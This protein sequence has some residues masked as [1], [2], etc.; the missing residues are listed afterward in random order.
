[1]DKSCHEVCAQCERQASTHCLLRG[2]PGRDQTTHFFGRATRHAGRASSIS[3]R[4]TSSPCRRAPTGDLGRSLV[5]RSASGTMFPTSLPSR[6][7]RGVDRM[8]SCGGRCKDFVR[9]ATRAV[10]HG[11]DIARP[12]RHIVGRA[13]VSLTRSAF[14]FSRT[15][16]AASRATRVVGR[17]CRCVNRTRHKSILG[18]RAATIA[19][20]SPSFSS[21]FTARA[22]AC[23]PERCARNARGAKSLP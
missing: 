3:C 14:R 5:D 11:A 15:T 20:S 10:D 12:R 16:R 7:T 19:T 4:T 17:A 21:F 23:H 9:L 1:M 13:A 8:Q 18:R 6:G 2:T 22:P